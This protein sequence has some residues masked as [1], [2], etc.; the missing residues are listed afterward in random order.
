MCTGDDL[1]RKF[2]LFNCA[3]GCYNVII[4]IRL[5]LYGCLEYKLWQVCAVKQLQINTIKPFI[6]SC[7]RNLNAKNARKNLTS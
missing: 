7:C 2:L 6:L 5:K 1:K 3:W 4:A